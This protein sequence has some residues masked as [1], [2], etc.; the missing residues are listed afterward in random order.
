MNKFA[1]QINLLLA[2]LFAVGLT[3]CPDHHIDAPDNPIG[4]NNNKVTFV[5]GDPHALIAGAVL[6]PESPITEANIESWRSKRLTGIRQYVEHEEVLK[7]IKTDIIKE[8]ETQDKSKKKP[9]Y[10]SSITVD[11]GANGKWRIG[12]YGRKTF[13]ELES[14]PDGRLQPART[15]V[16]DDVTPVRVLHWSVSADGN[17]SSVL[18][19]EEDPKYG[20]ALLAIYFENAGPEK[21]FAKTDSRFV[22]LAG[23]GNKISWNLP[24]DGNLQI[25]LC[26]APQYEQ[27]ARTAVEKW[28]KGLQ[29]RVQINFSATGSFFPFTELNQHCIYVVDS[30]LTDSRS[31][32]VNSG[33]TTFLISPVRMEIFDADIFLFASEMNKFDIENLRVGKTQDSIEQERRQNYFNTFAHEIGHVLG[34]G[35]K[36]DGTPSLMSYDNSYVEPTDYDFKAL[37]ELYPERK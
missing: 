15:I 14:T 35:H 28:N 18:L 21:E 32:V 10:D 37:Y 2:C 1:V 8:N 4:D 23:P 25:Q 3:A 6:N 13:L 17:Y 29:N 9:A 36:F 24:A 16:G 27:M 5:K 33:S 11:R 12:F 7:I 26:G 34:L 22:Y 31:D 20:R 19:D 30:Y